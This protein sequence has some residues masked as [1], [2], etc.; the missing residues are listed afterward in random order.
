[1]ALRKL[2]KRVARHTLQPLIRWYLR[3]PRRY[4]HMGMDLIVMPGVFHPGF[5]ISTKL[6]VQFLSAR[7]LRGKTLLE[8]GC[9]SGMVSVFAALRGAAVT[10]S[11]INP[12]AAQSAL[13]NAE[14]NHVLVQVVQSDLFTHLPDLTWDI[15]VI[16]PPYY[17]H[18]P[19]SDAERAWYCGEGFEY[20]VSL[21]SQLSTHTSS[22]IFMILSQDCD[23][24]RISAIATQ[25]G[26]DLDVAWEGRAGGEKN[27][28]FSLRKLQ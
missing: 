12:V 22:E 18:T 11:D 5:F 28:I 9:G 24:V 20:F 15:I 4:R 7:E 14:R 27:T 21:F 6:L 1:M 16:N 8:L 25:A 10:A 2:Y 17:P 23:L 3:K 26:W 13:T 19:H